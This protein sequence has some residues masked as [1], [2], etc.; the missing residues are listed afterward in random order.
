MDKHKH[1]D[2][3]LFQVDEGAYLTRLTRKYR[4]RDRWE[5]PDPS[6]VHSYIPGMVVRIMV[7]EGQR[8]TA[9]SPLLTFEAMK[10]ENTLTMPYD[11]VVKR[12]NV[13]VGD[14]FPKDIVL[15]VVDIG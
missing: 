9:G 15:A 2:L 14:V 8:L 1:G 11:G 13:K 6:E 12:I 4:E 3:Q 7:S 5:V 10:M